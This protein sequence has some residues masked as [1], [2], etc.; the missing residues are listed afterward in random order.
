[1]PVVGV[2]PTRPRG[3]ASLSRSRLPFRHT[4]RVTRLSALCAAAA[5]VLV[6]TSAAAAPGDAAQW[7]TSLLAEIPA[8]GAPLAVAAAPDG[9]TLYV[10]TAGDELLFL[11]VATRGVTATVPI[12]DFAVFGV[13]GRPIA[14]RED[15]AVIVVANCGDGTVSVIDA[16]TAS[17]D[18][19]LPVGDCPRSVAF[20]GAAAYVSGSGDGSVTVVDTTTDSVT[21]TVSIGDEAWGSAATPDGAELWVTDGDTSAVILDTGTNAVVGSV[22]GLDAPIDVAFSPDGTTAF[23]LD[24]VLGNAVAVVDRASGAIRAR[25]NPGIGFG[26]MPPLSLALSPDGDVLYVLG[27]YNEIGV[28]DTAALT[29]L[30]VLHVAVSGIFPETYGMALSPDGTVYVA[31]EGDAILVYGYVG[32]SIA[33]SALPDGV[34]GMPY[35]PA[36]LQATVPAGLAATLGSADKPDWLTIDPTSGL[37]S[38]TPPDAGS[39]AFTVTGTDARGNTGSRALDIVVHDPSEIE[40]IVPVPSQARVREGST[41]TLSLEAELFGGG[42]VPIPSG[43]AYASDEP[44]DVVDGDAVTF[45]HASTHTITARWG[46][47]TGQIA[48]VVIPVDDAGEVLWPNAVVGD[49][50]GEVIDLVFAPDSRRVYAISGDA[51]STIDPATNAVLASIP[52]DGASAVALSPDGSLAAVAA[53]PAAPALPT[54]DLI[55]TDTLAAV[56][57]LLDGEP[58]GVAFSPDGTT[59]YVTNAAGPGWIIDVATRTVVGTIPVPGV[60]LAVQPGAARLWIDGG[61]SGPTTVVE[62]PSGGIVTTIASAFDTEAAFTPDGATAALCEDQWTVTLLDAAALTPEAVL[63]IPDDHAICRFAVSSDGRYLYL[64]TVPFHPDQGG[65]GTGHLYRIDLAT[66]GIDAT[67]QTYPAP[68]TGVLGEL[69]LA[70]DGGGGYAVE[71]APSGDGGGALLVLGYVGPTATFLA[72][73]GEEASG[74][75]VAGAALLGAGALLGGI[76]VAARRRPTGTRR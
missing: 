13:P 22:T 4:G 27:P 68:A 3:Q 45:L 42:T 50:G 58:S 63:D 1:M 41:I 39:Y 55:E 73:T 35:G 76:A 2:E 51:F 29:R 10:G 6:P 74:P 71:S 75:V 9:R 14:V 67:L 20:V 18:A 64:A 38:G 28:I 34:A 44:S 53:A 37:L 26:E 62:V 59:L 54:V 61:A 43:V 56:G 17:V 57:L 19:T 33:T 21:A 11:D 49:V 31:D 8:R 25:I 72:A 5:I 48:I 23:V 70:P 52:L 30:Q 12:G 24:M 36:I 47:F 15:G 7:A 40:E 66:R 46:A 16:A 65:E 69:A 32:P 60:G